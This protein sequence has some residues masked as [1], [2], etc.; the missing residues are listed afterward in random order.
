MDR[1]TSTGHSETSTKASDAGSTKNIT[2]PNEIPSDV[3]KAPVSPDEKPEEKEQRKINGI[4][5]RV[6]GTVCVT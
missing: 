1:D 5:V 2:P 4:R 6:M 3:E